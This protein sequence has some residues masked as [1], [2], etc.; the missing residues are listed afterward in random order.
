MQEKMRLNHNGY[1]GIGTSG[2]ATRLSS[3]S[4]RFA[5]D[6]VYGGLSTHLDS[7]NWSVAGQGWA[8][9][10]VNTSAAVGNVNG[11]LLVKLTSSHSGDKLFALESGGINRM[12]V[13]GD[14]NVG[15]GTT[16]PTANLHVAS[17]TASILNFQTGTWAAKIFN[18][19]DAP[20][21]N[22]LIVGN[23]WAADSSTVFEVGTLYGGGSAWGSFYKVLG[24]G[25]H[26]FGVSTGSAAP[27]ERVRINNFGIGLN[28]SSP[29]SGIGI[30]FPGTQ[31]ASSDVN[32]LDDY[33]EGTWT[34]NVN[35]TATG[36]FTVKVGTYVKIGKQVTIWFRCDSGTS[37]TGGSTQYIDGL[38]FNVGT[39][40]DSSMVGTM[41]TNGPTNRIQNLL[42]LTANR[43]VLYIYN[44]GSQ[45]QTPIT[46][47]S[48]TAT[49]WID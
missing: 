48:G 15:I 6:A 27:N 13:K 34:P 23:R 31:S 18:Q 7:I 25:I 10:F 32:T 45:E 47:A 21:Y 39:Y 37:G 1:L 33:E 28:G 38:P 30:K 44:G 20:D 12:F 46:Y 14:G 9:A 4:T 24:S 43:A 41:G 3:S 29:T 49:Y 2:P 42:T 8:G 40:S 35:S 5:E 22:G 19:T 36:T 26:T 17:G 16:T 11:G